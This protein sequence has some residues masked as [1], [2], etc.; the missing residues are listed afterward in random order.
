M[1]ENI[2][3]T[4]SLGPLADTLDRLSTHLGQ[5]VTQRQW[6]LIAEQ[7][8]QGEADTVDVF[9]T[10]KRCGVSTFPQAELLQNRLSCSASMSFLL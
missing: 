7:Q 10:A 2:D 6:L 1:D 4:Q 5:S 3:A 9:D 8:G